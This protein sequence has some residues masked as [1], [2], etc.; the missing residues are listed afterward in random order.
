MAKN[1]LKKASLVSLFFLL[2]NSS[3]ALTQSEAELQKVHQMIQENMEQQLKLEQE[4]KMLQAKIEQQKRIVEAKLERQK[5]I[6]EAQKE[7]AMHQRVYSI[8][9]AQ[10]YNK[11]DKAI[12]DLANRLFSSSR[13]KKEKIASIA[14]TSFVNL[15]NFDN[16][17]HF[18]RTLSEA[19]FDELYIRGFNVNDFRGQETV[20]INE[21]G[22][23]LLTR[24][25]Q[26]LDKELQSGHALV[27][28]YTLF[29]KKALINVRVI[30]ITSGKVV[31]SAR[32]NYITNDC[33]VLETCPKQ[34]KIFI[35]SDKFN[36]QDIKKAKAMHQMNQAHNDIV[37]QRQKQFYIRKNHQP[38]NTAV[39]DEV[40]QTKTKYPLVN[41]I[42]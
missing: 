29:E 35:V 17:S 16:T 5:K 15:H 20:T 13:I 27:G 33:K 10:N 40:V 37:M 6:L 8:P 39:Q 22:E 23:Y 34:R 30:D 12:Q 25:I 7:V 42:K 21:K 2:S 32:A 14:L 41:L 11:I 38:K 31:A 18:G 24:D 4:S 19:F 26:K 1:L 9:T 28:T 3:Y 36:K